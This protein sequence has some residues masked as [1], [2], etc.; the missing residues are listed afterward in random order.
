VGAKHSLPLW[1]EHRLQASENKVL[2]KISGPKKGKLNEQFRAVHNEKLLNLYRSPSIE[3]TVK[4]RT[5]RRARKKKT[6]QKAN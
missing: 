6:N 4:S 2:R 1:E 3:G 5:L